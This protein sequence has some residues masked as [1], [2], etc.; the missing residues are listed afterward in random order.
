MRLLV[1]V[2]ACCLVGFLMDLVVSMVE[3]VVEAVDIEE[4]GLAPGCKNFG[5]DVCG[6]AC[7]H[8]CCMGMR[9]FA[10]IGN[11]GC[12]SGGCGC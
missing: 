4:L 8:Q 6:V 12:G 5:R 7:V 11:D 10:R 1:S 9:W 2:L 3:A